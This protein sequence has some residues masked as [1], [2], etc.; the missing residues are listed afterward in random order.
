M[1][2]DTTSTTGHAPA[3]PPPAPTM[4]PP[5]PARP[6]VVRAG[7]PAYPLSWALTAATAA[8][9]LPTMFADG[10]L[11]GPAAMNGSARGTAAV[12]IA[13]AAPGVVVGAL[14]TARGHVAAVPVWLGS[15]AYL[16]YNAVMLLLGTPFNPLFLLYVAT[17]S[18]A[19]W[20]AA[21][22]V[23]DTDL[24]AF[25]GP[26]GRR[27]RVVA[28]Y[29]WV[30]VALNTLVWLRGVVPGMFASDDPAFLAGTGL[31][32]SPTY[33]QDLTVWL[34]LGAVAAWWLWRGRPLG[35]FVLGAMLVMWVVESVGIAVDQW[36]GHAADP[37]SPA[38]VV[39]TV[40][41]FLV[42]AVVGLVPTIAL[43]RRR[44]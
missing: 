20:T 1:T 40:P 39:A 6:A 18:L 21:L 3:A 7:S 8:A 29:A 43:L 36:L 34:P 22:L 26:T 16:V 12:M 11:H 42:M 4:P 19:L 44:A 27:E 9:A 28:G 38:V 33:V 30:V 23:H 24:S 10:V 37:T 5:T 25:T 41:G 14:A 32:T 31:T 17:G 2:T 13:V 15:V 35:R